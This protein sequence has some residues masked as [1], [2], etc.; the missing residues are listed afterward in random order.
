MEQ[1]VVEATLRKDFGKS[2]SRRTRRR[3]AIP[4]IVYGARNKPVPV[5]VNPRRV[6]EILH[7]PSGYNTIFTL[8]IAGEGKA[9][10]MLKDWQLDPVR[11][12]LLHV[13]LIRVALTEK[14]RVKIP[15]MLVGEA[16]GVKVQGGVLEQVTRE[17]EVECLP[18]DIP[19]HLSADVSELMIGKQLRVGELVVEA[20]VKVLTDRDR[21]IAHVVSIKEEVVAA[22]EVV[23]EA[24]PAEPEV[25]KKGKAAAEE[26]EVVPTGR[27]AEA[28]TP[29]RKEKEKK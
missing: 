2:A 24:A 27:E 9:N 19:D 7:S 18:A 15:V 20:K 25:I 29:A 10:V 1:I 28:E 12:T 26:E 22:P 6:L 16:K 8:N 17:V 11:E 4:A 21:V 23:V 3:G 5:E 14:L 13:D